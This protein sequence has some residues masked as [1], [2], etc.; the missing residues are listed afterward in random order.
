MPKISVI[1]GIYN[2]KSKE[3]LKKS[4]NSI[5]NQ[6]FTDFELIICDDG[7]TN[8]CMKW[9]KEICNND[10]RVRFISNET[11]MGLAYTLNHCLKETKGKYIARMDD[12]DES[13]LKRFEIQIKY[14]ENNK[15]VDLVSSNINLFDESGIYGER[16]Y[17]EIIRKE[18][19]LF[20]SPIVHP[21]IMCK[22][23]AYDRVNGYRDIKDTV[24]VED[25]DLFMRMITNNICMRVIQDKLLNYRDD[26]SNTKRRKKY[27]YRINEAKIRLYN[28]KKMGLLPKGYIYVIKPLVIGMMPTTIVHKIKNKGS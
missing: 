8:D 17:S 11:N 27:M 26:L 13:N 20:N 16:K 1:M 6:T 18:D 3:Y 24:R 10:K 7:S 5:L 22:K 15:N 25:Y 4:L 23:S 14:L 12:D 21:A 2:T 9:V 19:F 28:F